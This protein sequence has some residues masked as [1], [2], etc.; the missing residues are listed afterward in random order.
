M[1]RPTKVDRQI[2]NVLQVISNELC[3]VLNGVYLCGSAVQ[4]G[5]K[6]ESDIDILVVV[7]KK[8]SKK[9]KE[10]L[11]EG[12]RPLSRKIGE[13]NSLRYLEITVIVDEQMKNWVYP[14]RQD[15][16]Y[17]EWLQ[18]DYQL[19]Y[20]PNNEPN[21]D[22]TILLYQARNYY[23]TLIGKYPLEKFLPKIPIEDV[24]QAIMNSVNELVIN[25]IGDETNV[26]LT[27]CRMILTFKTGEIYPKDIAGKMCAYTL[28][29]NHRHLILLAVNVY[30]GE[31]VIQWEK[32][33][34]SGTID[35]LYNEL[36]KIA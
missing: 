11:I 12:I 1:V 25:Y 13:K 19:G 14:P 31:E 3:E 6:A 5:L 27:L 24:K 17:G 15:F 33:D 26:I 18:N 16:I 32:Y 9:N 2:D 28:P 34:V 35:Y 20:V 10:N 36:I 7:S 8:L 22:L 23:K 4:G 30:R 29:L 21:P